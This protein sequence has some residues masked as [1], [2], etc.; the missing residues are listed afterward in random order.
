MKYSPLKWN[1]IL[2]EK[3][4]FQC[5]WKKSFVLLSEFKTYKAIYS[6]LKQK[7]SEKLSSL[8]NSIYLSIYLL[9]MAKLSKYQCSIIRNYNKKL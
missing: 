1:Y 3:E 8:K 9:K 5:Y 7:N 6:T 4:L 2:W